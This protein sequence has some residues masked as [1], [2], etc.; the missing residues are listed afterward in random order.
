LHEFQY[1]ATNKAGKYVA[2][3]ICADDESDLRQRLHSKQL[4]LV[5]F[6]VAESKPKQNAGILAGL[7]PITQKDLA[8]FSWQFYTMIDAGIP[9]VR[10]LNSIIKQTKN[11]RLKGVIR[12]VIGDISKGMSLSESLKNHPRVFSSF[13]VSMVEVGEIGGQLDMLLMD[14]ANYYETSVERRSKIIS[15]LSYPMLLFVGC[16]GVVFFLL[17]FLVPRLFAMFENIGTDIPMTTMVLIKAGSFLKEYLLYIFGALAAAL[18]ALRYY[19]RRPWGQYTLDSMILRIPIAGSI[20]KKIILSRFSHSLS[21]M[22]NGGVPLLNSLRI[23]RDIV[24]NAAVRHV[25]DDLIEG[26]SEGDTINEV[27]SRHHLIPD[28]VVNMVAVGEDTGTLSGMLTKVSNYYDREVNSAINSIT[29]II[30]PV[31]LV[32]MA[33]MVGFIAIS[34]L[35]PVTDLITSVNR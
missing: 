2:G 10:A 15:A 35:D 30:E 21:I 16:V 12:N 29:K 20:I 26:V 1:K 7:K 5:N 8:L 28:M 3:V 33:A 22:I 17:L 14:I 13:F 19:A 11:E 4:S 18:F 24:R 31:M 34:I 23:T 32:G 6:S 25:V 27:L 9:L